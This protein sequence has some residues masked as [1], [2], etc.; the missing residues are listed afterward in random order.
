MRLVPI[1]CILVVVCIVTCCDAATNVSIDASDAGS[2]YICDGCVK[3]VV[4]PNGILVAGYIQG[5]AH[6]PTADV[7]GPITHAELSFLPFTD[8]ISHSLSIYAF[9]TGGAAATYGDASKGTLLGSL[10][11]PDNVSTPLKFD[12]TNF[13]KGTQ[14]PYV[15]FNFRNNGTAIFAPPQLSVTFVPEPS[16]L[17]LVAISFAA[18]TVRRC[19]SVPYNLA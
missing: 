3:D 6:Y 16:T 13:L 1:T 9:A 19:K 14:A 17:T 5:I 18:F 7:G 15:A 11:L 4:R 10:T 12:V 2:L 8:P